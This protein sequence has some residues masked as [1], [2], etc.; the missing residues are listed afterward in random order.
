[1]AEITTAMVK[2]LRERTGAGILECKK[3]LQETDGDMDKAIEL[4][5]ERGIAKAAK[6]AHR[7]AMQGV[8]TSYIHAGN[9]IGAMVELNCE[10]DFV[11]RTPQFQEL[12]YNIAMQIAA[13]SPQ[14]VSREDVPAEV[15]EKEKAILM[16]QARQEGRPEHILERIVEGRLDKF[17]QEVCLLEQPYIR[18]QSVTIQDLIKQHIA[19]LGENIVV[20]RFCRMAVGEVEG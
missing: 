16:E 4:L 10:T 13:T 15:I 2:E 11:A 1:M 14:Y 19:Q 18:D 12:A 7:V 9:Q 20:R 3:V 5:R 17:F 8:I 6:K